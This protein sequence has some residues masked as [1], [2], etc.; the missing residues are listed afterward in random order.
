[1]K[2]A[3]VMEMRFLHINTA[4]VGCLFFKLQARAKLIPKFVLEFHTV[5]FEVLNN[6]K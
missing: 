4:F 3:I 2:F 5:W 6:D 1:M